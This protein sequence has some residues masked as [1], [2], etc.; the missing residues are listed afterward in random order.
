MGDGGLIVSDKVHKVSMYI[1]GIHIL[2]SSSDKSVF[3]VCI[4]LCR[5]EELMHTKNRCAMLYCVDYV[6]LERG[7]TG[8]QQIS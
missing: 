4:A 5:P 7:S 2:P 3:D 1:V 6:Q 8:V